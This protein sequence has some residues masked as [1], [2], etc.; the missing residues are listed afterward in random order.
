MSKLQV[1]VTRDSV[2]MGDDIDAPH[3]YSFSL[4]SSV[5]L[6]ELFSHLER[7]NYLASVAGFNHTWSAIINMRTVAS[8]KGNN[9]KPEP[10][11]TLSLPITKY[12]DN[13]SVKIK[14]KYHSS[15]T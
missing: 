10:N 7:K 11:K 6:A 9:K 15:A 3:S 4:N 2:C 1:Q 12:A 13:G 5:T 14:F 8:F